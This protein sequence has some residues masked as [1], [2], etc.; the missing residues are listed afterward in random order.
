MRSRCNR[1][2]YCRSYCLLNMYGTLAETMALLKPLQQESMLLPSK[3]FHIQSLHQAGKLNL[4]QCLNDSNPFFQL[5]FSHPH[6]T[7]HKTEP[8]N[9][10]PANRT[11]KPQLHTRSATWK[12]Q[13]CTFSLQ[14]HATIRHV[15]IHTITPYKRDTWSTDQAIHYKKPTKNT[16]TR[17]PQHSSHLVTNLDNTRHLRLRTQIPQK[18]TKLLFTFLQHEIPQAATTV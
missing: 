2:F 13:V 17:P 3:Q 9:Q 14:M 15:H 8:V 16:H 6:H 4:E 5:A 1:G 18:L 7:H 11:H 12:P 10:H